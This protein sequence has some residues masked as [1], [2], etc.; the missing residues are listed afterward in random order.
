MRILTKREN[1][2]KLGIA[3]I[4]SFISFSI[5]G[6]DTTETFSKGLL[7]EYEFYYSNSFQKQ[8]VENSAE[9]L[10]GGS[11]KDN[12]SYLMTV[13]TG[14]ET[15]KSEE[16]I[17]TIGGI[18]FGLLYTPFENKIF[19][20][21]IMPSFSFEANETSTNEK[22]RYPN[23]QGLSYGISFEINF[24]MFNPIQPYLVFGINKYY[25]NEK[26]NNVF[27][28]GETEFPITFGFMIPIREGIELFLQ[29]DWN[30]T[31]NNQKWNKTKRSFELG[32]NVILTKK[33]ELI[34]GFATNLA[35]KVN[36]EKIP[37]SYDIN[38]GFI[39]AL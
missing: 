33:L 28:D 30:L 15:P 9:F 38:I 14:V 3:L 2:I 10:I 37:I 1:I 36:T 31:E 25:Q 17:I 23:F 12:L 32:L 18:G 16:S 6:A 7:T 22:K 35:I 19:A 34:T 4:I 39:Y 29:L 11:F 26:T 20:F 8:S 21:D 27:E 5:H 24:T 13:A